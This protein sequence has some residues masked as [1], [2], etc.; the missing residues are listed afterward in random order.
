MGR[1]AG[2]GAPSHLQLQHDQPSF[3]YAINLQTFF[4]IR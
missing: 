3:N 4:L 1:T 2:A